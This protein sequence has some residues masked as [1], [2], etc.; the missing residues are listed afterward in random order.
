MAKHFKCFGLE[1]E[2]FDEVFNKFEALGGSIKELA[3][4]CLEFIPDMINPNLHA[5]MKKHH[6]SGDTEDSL[7]FDDGHVRWMGTTAYV[8][9]GFSISH[10]GL[11]SIFLMYGTAR[12]APKN[13]YG[14]AKKDKAINEG[15]TADKALYNDIY[16]TSTK[17]KIDDKQR[18]ICDKKI[19]KIM[20]K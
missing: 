7:D 4:D 16:G 11:A 1:Y 13:Q 18:D 8:P 3:E 19:Q 20:G 6:R 10:G 17:R 2:G 12:H 5:D 15:M 14:H 9:V